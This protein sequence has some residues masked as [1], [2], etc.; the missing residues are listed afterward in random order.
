MA[1]KKPLAGADE[2]IGASRLRERTIDLSNGLTVRIRELSGRDRFEL[3]E[4]S[5]ANRWDVMVWM[6]QRGLVVPELTIEQID[7]MQPLVVHEIAEAVMDMSGVSE[8]AQEQAGKSSGTVMLATGG[9]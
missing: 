9:S 4:Q 7:G 1:N 3:A 6:A 2:I 8:T 5:E